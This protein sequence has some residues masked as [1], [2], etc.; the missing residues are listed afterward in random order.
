MLEL[1]DI[2]CKNPVVCGVDPGTNHVGFSSL[3]LDPDTLAIQRV[4][5]TSLRVDKLPDYLG[6]DPTAHTERVEKLLKIRQAVVKLLKHWG[7]R[8]LSCESPFYNRLRPGAYGPL[9]ES[10]LM[11]KLA[12]FEHNPSMS[13]SPIEPSVI[14]KAVGA[15][16]I[17][18][19]YAVKAAILKHPVLSSFGYPLEDLDEHALDALAVAFAYWK[20]HLTQGQKNA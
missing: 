11:I 3:V 17:S 1:P 6:Y 5:A 18:D 15:G 16:H 20:S 2:C 12:A 13:F 19:K 14:K 7:P 4:W 9:V 8:H 10:V